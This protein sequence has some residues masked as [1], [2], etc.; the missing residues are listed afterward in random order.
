M[1][2]ML[3]ENGI[4]SNKESVQEIYSKL[5]EGD[6]NGNPLTL[7]MSRNLRVFAKINIL[8]RKQLRKVIAEWKE[9]KPNLIEKN[10]QFI[11]SHGEIFNKFLLVGFDQP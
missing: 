4:I 5:R 1:S 11:E 3:K 8:L 6:T 10:K 7:M 2:K 9:G